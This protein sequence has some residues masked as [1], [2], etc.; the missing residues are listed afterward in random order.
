MEGWRIL[1][2]RM[3]RAVIREITYLLNITMSVLY[4]ALPSNKTMTQDVKY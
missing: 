3:K 4:S 2:K 1:W